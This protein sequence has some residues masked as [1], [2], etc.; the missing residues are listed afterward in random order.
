MAQCYKPRVVFLSVR[1][2]KKPKFA[3]GLLELESLPIDCHWPLLSM[4]DTKPA[5]LP[6][7]LLLMSEKHSDWRRETGEGYS[8]AVG[9]DGG[10]EGAMVSTSDQ[11]MYRLCDIGTNRKWAGVIGVDGCGWTWLDEEWMKVDVGASG[12]VWGAE[13]G[14]IKAS[15]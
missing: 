2:L 3:K 4:S 1:P 15:R 11:D 5:E 10:K 14:N 9:P 8:A 12:W 7:R 6:L 13:L